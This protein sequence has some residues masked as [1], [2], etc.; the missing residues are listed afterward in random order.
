[1]EFFDIFESGS[2]EGAK[3]V[4]MVTFFT[5]VLLGVGTL[6]VI[7][8]IFSTLI[9]LNMWWTT[10]STFV[11]V[12]TDV[13]LYP[14]SDCN[15][16]YL[17]TVGDN[18]TCITSA[19]A[20]S[21]S[22]DDDTLYDNVTAILNTV[23]PTRS[24]TFSI[25][26]STA[27]GTVLQTSQTSN[28]T[29]IFPDISGTSVVSQTGTGLVLI[30]QNGLQD[31]GS[32]AGIQYS[33]TTAN[34]AQI[35]MNQYGANNAG[36]GI[37]GFKSRSPTIGVSEAVQ[38]N[39]LLWRMTAI[40]VSGDNS[41]IPLAATISI[42]VAAVGSNYV[43]TDFEVALVDAE[44]VTNGRRPVFDINSHGWP[45]FLESTSTNPQPAPKTPPSDVVTL[46]VGG[47]FTV[48]NHNIPANARILLTVQPGQA[49]LGTIYV[50]AIVAS[51]S[52]TIASTNA[53]DVGVSVYYLLF[54]PLS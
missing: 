26:G 8:S 34:R 9:G 16:T 43:G 39:D 52:F 20:P 18:Q 11:H 24:L 48:A 4:R 28:R 22:P 6:L 31:H 40:G 13:K 33:S 23:D 21:P 36:P 32:N 51:T 1:M 14:S 35:R 19:S 12:P 50:S 30:N 2:K 46:G 38:V 15:D 10:H 53:G 49:P 29:F 37:T 54:V 44:G 3:P 7:S 45:R 42:N 47:T 41:T 25:L 17:I 27:T 5:Y